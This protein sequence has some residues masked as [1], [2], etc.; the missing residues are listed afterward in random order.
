METKNTKFPKTSA[1]AQNALDHAGIHSLEELSE[2]SETEIAKLHGMGP[3]AL[4]ILR[5]AL[6]DIGL[7]FAIKTKPQKGKG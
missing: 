3:K 2:Y 6:A 1:P 7:S 5:Q 4:G